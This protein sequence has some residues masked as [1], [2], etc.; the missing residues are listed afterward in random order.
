MKPPTNLMAKQSGFDSVLVTWTAPSP[1]PTMGYRVTA[2]PGG[3]SV[4]ATFG[5]PQQLT[6]QQAGVYSIE[7]V[8]LSQ[9]LPS[10]AV[11]ANVTVRGKQSIL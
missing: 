2:E 10:E 11:S 5:S 9:H 4:D 6:I 8:S 1:P 7:V 3:L